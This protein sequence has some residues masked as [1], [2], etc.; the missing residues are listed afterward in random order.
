MA[1]PY[2]KSLAV[3]R[4]YRRL[5]VEIIRFK[6][7]SGMHCLP[8]C[9]ACCTK[10]DIEAYPI[11]FLP[12]AYDLHRKNMA[13]Q[14]FEEL[15]EHEG[16]VCVFLKPLN[17]HQQGGGCSNYLYRGLICRLFGFSARRDKYN[18]PQLV[19]CKPIKENQP[20]E[21]SRG[22]E[23]T[24]KKKIPLYR[25]YYTQLYA[26]EPK[27]ADKALPINKAILEAVEY[28]LSYYTY[29]PSRRVKKA[30]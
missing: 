20:N 5:E 2:Y 8:G 1:S 18:E 15:R 13:Y 7:K 14:Y 4:V 10:P 16:S 26:I 25:D 6:G 9:F 22:V 19:T 12:F 23:L 29:R 24:Q 3:L 30:S 28:I 21:V 17:L 11:E 27:L